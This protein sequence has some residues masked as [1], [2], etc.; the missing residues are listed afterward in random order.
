MCATVVKS[1]QRTDSATSAVKPYQPSMADCRDADARTAAEEEDA[2][3]FDAAL[4]LL[5]CGAPVA[6]SV[7]LEKR[8]VQPTAESILPTTVDDLFS[9]LALVPH[10][11]A[12]FDLRLRFRFAS[13]ASLR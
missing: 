9:L 8:E 7:A 3:L 2:P 5:A 12:L 1:L 13:R 10:A 4:S 6:L 11:A